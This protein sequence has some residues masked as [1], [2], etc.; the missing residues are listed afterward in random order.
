MLVAARFS[1]TESISDDDR[2]GAGTAAQDRRGVT[3]RQTKKRLLH[4]NSLHDALFI[5]VR[6]YALSDEGTYLVDL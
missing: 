6:S 3:R 4:K 1:R 5:D 2:L